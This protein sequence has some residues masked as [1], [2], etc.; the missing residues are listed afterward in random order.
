M[1]VVRAV[2]DG[3][4]LLFSSNSA[5]S[6]NVALL[7]NIPY[8]PNKD[9][10][11]IAGVAITALVLMVRPDF[12]AKTVAEFI[13]YV[14]Q[15][16]GKLSAGYGSSS[17]QVSLAMLNRMAGIDVL[18]APYKG[19]PAA[20]NDV[21]GGTLDFTFIDIGNAMA[22]SKGGRL[23]PLAINTEK[24]NSLVPDWPTLAET[25][26]GFDIAAW[27]AVA[28]PAGMPPQVI[29]TL[30]TGIAAAIKTPD[31]TQKLAITGFA[32]M[33]MK[34]GQLKTFVADEI[35]KWKQL[36]KDANLEA[37]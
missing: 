10:S 14:K 17:S 34:P 22:Q 33:P 21:I 2:P 16:P 29:E 11:P 35:V 1:E 8:D 12:P 30:S 6:S 36:A 24:R 32:P 5:L 19:M 26:P 23:R 18:A 27:V 37:Q 15:R 13:A 28:G 25:L 9:L 4:T 3:Y 7:K 20:A 31:V